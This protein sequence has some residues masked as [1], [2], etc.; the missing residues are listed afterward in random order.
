MLTETQ[1]Q[2]FRDQ[3][4]LNYGPVLTPDETQA[5]R[6]ALTRTLSGKSERKPETNRDIGGSNGVVVQI[7]NQWEVEPVFHTHLFHPQIVTMVAQLMGTDTVRVWHD[8]VQIKPSHIGGPTIW[9]QDFPYWPVIAPAELVSAWVALEDATVENGCMSMVPRSH[10][11]GAYNGGTVGSIP[12][13][14]GP[15]HDV[16]F[17]PEGESVEPVACEVPAGG[18]VFHHCM[19]WHGAPPNHT[20]R[21][22][23][24]IAVH[25]MPGH[26]R[27]EPTDKGHLVEEHISVKPGELLVGE[28]FPTVM[29]RGEIL[30]G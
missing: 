6:E 13:D 23:P 17:V 5:L 3:G 11:W 20:G 4:F 16:G 8:Q 9:H 18:V 1:I 10:K 29:E 7:V 22:R 27:Y 19:T 24:A 25:Y 21:G 28:H 12:D 14:W 15:A 26:T 2:T 30:K